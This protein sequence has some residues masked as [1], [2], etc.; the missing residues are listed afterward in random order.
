VYTEGCWVYENSESWHD[1]P[2]KSVTAFGDT[3]L[4]AVS[5]LCVALK[6]VIDVDIKDGFF[7]WVN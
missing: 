3:P 4:K 7:L 1:T 2:D 5:E 6:A